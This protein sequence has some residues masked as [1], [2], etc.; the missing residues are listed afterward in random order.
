MMQ[1]DRLQK[2][3]N[4]KDFRKADTLALEENLEHAAA[5]LILGNRD[6][7]AMQLR[8]MLDDSQAKP[9]AARFL[10]TAFVHAE[11]SLEHFLAHVLGN[12][13]AGIGNANERKALRVSS[14][15]HICLLY[16]SDAA[17]D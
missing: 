9:A 4:E 5:R 12:T 14:H 11:E 6:R 1:G 16:T 8:R 3:T 2:R 10:R 17:D 7:C 15:A 13:H